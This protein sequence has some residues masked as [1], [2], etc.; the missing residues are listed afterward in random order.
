MENIIIAQIN[1]RVGDLKHNVDKVIDIIRRNEGKTILFTELAICGY[2]AEDLLLD[3]GFVAQVSYHLANVSSICKDCKVSIIIGAPIAEGNKLYNAALYLSEGNIHIVHKKNFLPN[4]GVFDERR[5]FDVGENVN[6]FQL[7]DKK[8]A[9]LICED[10]W[11]IDNLNFL[12]D[13]NLDFLITLNASPFEQG[14]FSKRLSRAGYLVQE[15]LCPV[16]YLNLVGGQDNLVFD[17]RSFIFYLDHKVSLMEFAAEQVSSAKDIASVDINTLMH[18]EFADIYNVICLGIRDYF[19]KNNQTKA[20]IALSGGMDSALCAALTIDAI[21]KENV[22]LITLPSRYTGELSYKDAQHLIDAFEVEAK[23]I[24]IENIFQELQT[25]LK[26]A[27]AGFLADVTEEN[28][29]SRIRGVIMMSLSNKYNALVVTT[30]NKSEYACGYA[31][32]YGD[33]CGALAPIKDV[34]KTDVYKLAS[35]RNNNIPRLAKGAYKN[36]FTQS[37]LDKAPTAELRFD[38]KDSDSL[39]EY[40]LLDTFLKEF[41]EEKRQVYSINIKGID[42]SMKCHIIKM[43]RLSEYKRRQSAIGIKISKCSFDKDWRYPITNNYTINE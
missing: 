9:C 40:P 23:N 5:Y 32:I 3:E 27:F 10:F 19:K 21:G 4:T 38:Q 22:E 42:D 2:L 11:Q 29:Q 31:T 20:L 41:V 34:F 37:I 17:G 18:D 15:I 39:P 33:M 6:I 36:M 7:G 24:P 14:K 28:M 16:I 30:G 13:A 26:P 43:I 35:W 8:V 25:S 12:K 1:F